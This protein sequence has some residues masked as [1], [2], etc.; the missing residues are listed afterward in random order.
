MVQLSSRSSLSVPATRW[1]VIEKECY[2]IF[3]CVS[4]LS[5]YLTGKSFVILTDHNNLVWMQSS[6]VPKIVRMRIYLQQYTFKVAHIP[7]A[8]NEFAD[9]LPRDFVNPELSLLV[10]GDECDQDQG[11]AEQVEPTSGQLSP[12]DVIRLVHNGRMGHFGVRRTWKAL[13]KHVPGHGLSIQVV[14]EFIDSCIW[15]QK[16]R[17]DMSDSLPPPIRAVDPDHPRVFCG[18][19]TLFVSPADEEGFQY[20][21]VFKLIPSRLVGLYPSKDLSA[22]SLAEAMF[23]FF[24]TYGITEVI[25]TDPGSNINSQVVKTLLSWFGVRLRMSIVGRHESNYV[26]RTNREVLRFRRALVH[27]DRLQNVW[28]KPH[29]ICAIQFLL[30]EAVNRET[31]LSPFHYVFGSE[32]VRFLVLPSDDLVTSSGTFLRTLNGHLKLVREEAEGDQ[33][34]A[35]EEKGF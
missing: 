19:D 31:G 17:S 23:R 21:H 29:V 30:N 2:A 35:R 1:S 11:G 27:T 24:T 7:G 20:L 6:T 25:M 18:Y 14:R 28:S 5:Y 10:T 26:E 16:L 15:C 22:D 13:N 12:D 34:G 3:H 4:K 9:W 8:K 32:D 33:E